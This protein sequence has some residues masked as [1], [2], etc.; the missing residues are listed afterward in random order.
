MLEKLLFK[1]YKSFTEIQELEL[2]K[3]TVLIGKNSSGKSAICKLPTLLEQSVKG[4][5]AEAF[6]FNNNGVMLGAEY[7]DVFSYRQPSRPIYFHLFSHNQQELEIEV[8]IPGYEMNSLPNI[9]S[10]K[11]DTNYDLKYVSPQVY[12]NNVDNKQYSCLFNGF[13]L[14]HINYIENEASPGLIDISSFLFKTNYV[15]PFRVF[16]QSIRIFQFTSNIEDPN[17]GN[18]G[19][20][21]YQILAAES[22]KS[23]S[24]VINDVSNWFEQNFNGWKLKVVNDK[25]PFFEIHLFKDVPEYFSINIADAGQGM[26]QALPLIV[27]AF[28]ANGEPTLNIFEEPELHL[29][30]IAHANLAE[31]FAIT[32][33]QLDKK[34]LIETH[35]P[36]FVLRLRR[37]VAE[38][39]LPKSD[40]AIY[41][42][43]SDDDLNMS[44]LKKIN[45]NDDGSVDFW[46]EHIFKETLDETL[47]LRS[48][49]L[50]M[51][52]GN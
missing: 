47:A 41:W 9:F 48:V 22:L 51:K 49:Q 18:D 25:M 7:R 2:K 5:F 20:N 4:K 38:G 1:S 31:L 8:T 34:Y 6:K 40:L 17:I 50:K 52:N 27:S 37:L 45:V 10:W 19:L 32:A 35:S 12:F 24:T 33:L 43:D 11:L 36:S 46:P 26:S 14:K 29:H 28:I 15:G 30:P 39:T 3:I 23:E 21:A 16:S 44:T 42:V 13:V